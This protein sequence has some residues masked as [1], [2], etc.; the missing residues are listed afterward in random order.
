MIPLTYIPH[1]PNGGGYD[2]PEVTMKIWMDR[3][4]YFYRE[5]DYFIFPIW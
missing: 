3:F 1:M 4:T 5:Y 2:D